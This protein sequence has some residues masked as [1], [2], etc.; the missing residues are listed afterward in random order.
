LLVEVEEVLENCHLNAR[1]EEGPKAAR[2]AVLL[3]SVPV[4]GSLFPVT[5]L[6]GLLAG[7]LSSILP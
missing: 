6:S 3:F 5:R 4:V 7:L 1:V 2:A